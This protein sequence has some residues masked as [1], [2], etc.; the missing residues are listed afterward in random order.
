MEHMDDWTY[1]SPVLDKQET[2]NNKKEQL[3]PS[4]TWAGS[5]PASSSLVEAKDNGEVVLSLLL[6]LQKKH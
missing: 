3:L 4:L 2:D 6:Q 1:C 5:E